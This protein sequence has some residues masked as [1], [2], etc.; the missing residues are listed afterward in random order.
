ML[1]NVEISSIILYMRTYGMPVTAATKGNRNKT[2]VRTRTNIVHGHDDIETERMRAEEGAFLS[3]E[4][5]SN[6]LRVKV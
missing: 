4:R 6:N 2:H 1:E 3:G 5:R